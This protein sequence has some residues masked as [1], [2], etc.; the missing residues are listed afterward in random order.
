MN[1]KRALSKVAQP[2]LAPYVHSPLQASC[3]LIGFE[4]PSHLHGLRQYPSFLAAPPRCTRAYSLQPPPP[5]PLQCSRPVLSVS[6]SGTA[7]HN[8]GSKSSRTCVAMHC[9]LRLFTTCHATLCHA[10][11]TLY[12][13]V[14]TDVW[15]KGPDLPA[16]HRVSNEG[17]GEGG[18]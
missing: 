16:L 14:E 1:A 15:E 13:S 17:E 7:R 3:H 4:L 10:F 8:E 18:L 9:Y 12:Y 6:S 5:S 2:L 11:A